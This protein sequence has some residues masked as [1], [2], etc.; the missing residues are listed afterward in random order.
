MTRQY[1]HADYPQ[2][3]QVHDDG[4][5]DVWLNQRTS[6]ETS[7]RFGINW[8]KQFKTTSGIG[9]DG[10]GVRFADWSGDGKAEY[11]Y[12]END[13]AVI[14]YLNGGP[15]FSGPDDAGSI[16][17]L[18]QKQSAIGVGGTRANTAFA[19]VNGNGRWD[20]SFPSPSPCLLFSCPYKSLFF[21][22]FH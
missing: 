21:I 4:S 18:P 11:L 12:V 19:D 10:A 3:I 6:A 7:T 20:V 17:W 1:L 2:Y 9:R 22:L 15:R 8:I 13:G 16:N 5:C 14:T